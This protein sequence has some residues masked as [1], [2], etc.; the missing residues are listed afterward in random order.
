MHKKDKRTT[1][2]IDPLLL[3]GKT[4]RL[5][6]IFIKKKIIIY[7]IIIICLIWQK[8]NEITITNLISHTHTYIYPKWYTGYNRY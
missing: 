7:I 4:F 6:K 3:K 2:L 8:N 5:A 1:I